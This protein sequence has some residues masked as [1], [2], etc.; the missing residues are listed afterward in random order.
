MSQIRVRKLLKFQERML[1]T[2]IMHQIHLNTRKLLL[3]LIIVTKVPMMTKI[4]I[5]I[6]MFLNQILEMLCFYH[7]N[8]R[9]IKNKSQFQKQNHI[10][11][12]NLNQIAAHK[13]TSQM[14]KIIILHQIRKLRL[15]K[16]IQ[17]KVTSIKTLIRITILHQIRKLRLPKIIQSK[18]TS[19]K[20]LIRI[21][22]LHQIRKLRLTKIIQS[23][24]TS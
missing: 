12:L 7:Q 23:K 20:T 10:R 19:V 18:V 5:T 6:I 2:I 11:N 9:T 4:T 21:T 14:T 1:K 17:S 15:T 13:E 22:I 16:I 8:A 24:V 3:K